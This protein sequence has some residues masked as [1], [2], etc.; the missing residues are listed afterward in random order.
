MTLAWS[1]FLVYLLGTAYLAWLGHKRTQNFGSFAIGQGD[2]HPYVVGITLAA[3]VASAAT[4]II[5]PGFIY[6]HGVSAFM[7][8]VIAVGSGFCLMLVLLSFRFRQLGEANKALTMPH[9]IGERFRSKGFAL[10]FAVVNLFALA[11]VVLI[12]G[13][14]SIVLQQLLGVS[15]VVALI[16]I[17]GFVT[18][19]IFVGGTYAHAF[20]NTLQGT[21]MLLVTLTILISGLQLFFQDGPGFFERLAAQDPN[22]IA[23]VNPTSDLYNGVFS[24][25]ISGFII[26]AALVCQPH[27]LTKALYVKSDRAVRNYLIVAVIAL[28]LFFFL[29]FAGF[30]AR[31]TI[32]PEQLIDAA[33]GAFRQDLVM[34]VYLKNAFP[35]WAF[36][37]VSV[38]LLAAGMSTLDGILVALSTISA[39]DLLLN[40]IDRFG[41]HRLSREKQLSLAY[42]F[43]HIV[44]VAIAGAAFLICLNPP[45]LL[46]IFG[47]V[48]VYGMAVAAVPPLLGGILFQNIPLRLVW[49][50]SIIGLAVHL[51]LYFWGAKL[52][53]DSNLTFANPG[54]TAT[55]AILISLVLVI[56]G[57]SLL[58][59]NTE[60]KAVTAQLK[61]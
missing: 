51:L 37:T 30:Y 39:N 34:T 61:Q 56:G 12:V 25:Y 52:F 54:V 11:F 29:P 27:I 28:A 53:A 24:I 4:F 16:I 32:P 58:G 20:T 36:T 9:W 41:K 42:R 10:Y 1:L 26:G 35:G 59:I 49:A 8:F 55:L 44:L 31:V 45:K 19:Y 50:S 57:V 47:Q 13:G 2:M 40:L 33:T 46:G 60:R 18:S 22:L 48:G 43:S 6:V 5:N 3:S 15:N 17:L 7:H 14:L 21:L 38:V 23:L